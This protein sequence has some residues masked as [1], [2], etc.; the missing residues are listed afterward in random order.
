[1]LV[2]LKIVLILWTSEQAL[3]RTE[4][5]YLYSLTWRMIYYIFIWENCNSGNLG[6]LTIFKISNSNG[7]CFQTK[8]MSLD[9]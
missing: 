6:L 3:F 7:I 2:S 5:T 1:M 9:E 4:T 8:A